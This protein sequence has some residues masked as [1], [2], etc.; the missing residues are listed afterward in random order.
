M[1]YYRCKLM[2]VVYGLVVAALLSGG[3]WCG[4]PGVVSASRVLMSEEGEASFSSSEK[5]ASLFTSWKMK[6]AK[7]Y[8]DDEEHTHR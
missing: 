1:V 7:T 6:H 2:A 5:H 3:G 8:K 4:H